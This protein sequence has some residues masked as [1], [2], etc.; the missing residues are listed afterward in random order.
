MVTNGAY[1]TLGSQGGQILQFTKDI[2]KDIAVYTLLQKILQF[3]K[4]ITKKNGKCT[5]AQI[6]CNEEFSE[7]DVTI[8]VP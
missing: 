4:D 6:S 7:V 3:T 8:V 2:T 1:L 5:Y